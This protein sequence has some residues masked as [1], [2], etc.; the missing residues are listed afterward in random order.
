MITNVTIAIKTISWRLISLLY[1][2]KMGL[3]KLIACL[4][5]CILLFLICFLIFIIFHGLVKNVISNSSEVIFFIKAGWSGNFSKYS[6]LSNHTFTS[7]G[8]LAM[9][10]L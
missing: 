4:F 5:K 1:L 8:I 2:S 3:I 6:G 10:F 7:S 9:F